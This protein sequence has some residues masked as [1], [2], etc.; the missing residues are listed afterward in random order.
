VASRP[1]A[2]APA[3]PRVDDCRASGASRLVPI[4]GREGGTVTLARLGARPLAYVAD[5]DDGVIH[6]V[7]LDHQIE[8]GTTSA[9]GVPSQAL[10]TADGRLLVLLRDRAELRVFEP[11][12][13]PEAPLVSRCAVPL[14]D[15]PI[16][17]ALTPN[18]KTVLVTS[19]WGAR[20]TVLDAKALDVRAE[21]PLPREP[22]AVVASNDGKRAFVAHMV[23]SRMSV[24]DLESKG[25]HEVSLEGAVEVPLKR[26]SPRGRQ[27]CQGFALA[28][29]AKPEERILAPQVLVDTGD[30]NERPS[31]YGS[32]SASA[33][34]EVPSIA[35][36]DERNGQPI[37]DSLVLGVRLPV[38]AKRPARDCILPRAAATDEV[39]GQ[40][41]VACMG[42]NEVVAYDARG[43]DPR[44]LHAWQVA[45]GPNGIAVDAAGHRVVVFSQFDRELGVIDLGGATFEERLVAPQSPI[46][47]VPL[48]RRA[49][50]AAAADLAL[51]RRLFHAA[52]DRRISSDGRVCAS[53]HPDGRD[54]ALTWATPDGP[55]QTPMLA[56][57]LAA[58]APYGWHG[59][60]ADIKAHLKTTFQRLGGTGLEGP[61]LDALVAYAGS[62]APPSRAARPLD[63]AAAR[64]REIFGSAGC[65]SCHGNGVTPDGQAHA[66]GG[67]YGYTPSLEKFDTPSLRF[68]AGTAPY[69]HDG[70][71]ATLRE[72]LVATGESMG[73]T[74]DLSPEDL[75]AL[76]AYLRTL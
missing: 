22:R 60:G 47:H 62:M 17:L 20:L 67:G 49:Q 41:L 74:K 45:A 7:D 50:P 9:G 76:E 56:G 25:V 35:V 65:S 4:G 70:R 44:G 43:L 29:A 75:A 23:G 30:V 12:Q 42:S 13:T 15:E 14:A 53:C 19:A 26:A 57:R 46:I 64:G 31:G 3:A 61:E 16:A 8:I 24:V 71:Y 32:G 63:A 34:A 66:L 52:G 40:L 54:D 1:Q 37:K 27:G 69:F 38:N 73:N 68:V 28:K 33:P 58:S 18:D 55:R 72:L 59:N 11:G 51:G 39:G 2:R 10:V 6:V 21:V 48:S 5:E 36:I